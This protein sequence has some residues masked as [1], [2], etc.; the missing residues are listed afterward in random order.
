[1]RSIGM[2]ESSPRYE[3]Y[4]LLCQQ[5]IHKFVVVFKSISGEIQFG[6]QIQCPFRLHAGHTRDTINPFVTQHSLA[7]NPTFRCYQVIDALI[8]TH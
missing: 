5:F 2:I 7:V 3:Q 8:T 6:K 1:M 4:F